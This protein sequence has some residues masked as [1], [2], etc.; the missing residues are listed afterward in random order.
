MA[1]EVKGIRSNFSMYDTM[2]ES[3]ERMRHSKASL[4]SLVDKLQTVGGL[5]SESKDAA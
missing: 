3:G 5:D 2:S 1:I 4:N